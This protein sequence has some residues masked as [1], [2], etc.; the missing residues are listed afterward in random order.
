MENNIIT[1]YS[2][3]GKWG[4]K[5][6][7]NE[8]IVDAVYDSVTPFEGGFGVAVLNGEYCLLNTR[9]E[10]VLEPVY[11]E[12]APREDLGGYAFKK[13]GKWGFISLRG[14]KT[15]PRFEEIGKLAEGLIPVSESGKWGF[16]NSRFETVIP[17]SY[18]SAKGFRNG[19]ALVA[20]WHGN[21]F[22]IDRANRPV[23]DGSYKYISPADHRRYA[24]KHLN[25]LFTYHHSLPNGFKVFR[26]EHKEP[27]EAA[28][29]P[30]RERFVLDK[31]YHSVRHAG[32][33][34]IKAGI[35]TG[36]DGEFKWGVFDLNGDQILPV[37]FD[38]A[39]WIGGN[40]FAFKKG[41]KWG[42]VTRGLEVVREQAFDKLPEVKNGVL[43]SEKTSNLLI[44]R[45]NTDSELCNW[46][47]GRLID[48]GFK[49]GKT[50]DYHAFYDP[51]GS[52]NYY[53][54]E[55][56]DENRVNHKENAGLSDELRQEAVD[57][58]A[59]RSKKIE[60]TLLNDTTDSFELYSDTDGQPGFDFDFM[61]DSFSMSYEDAPAD[62][63]GLLNDPASWMLS[64]RIVR[65]EVEPERPDFENLEDDYAFFG[66]SLND[67]DDFEG[68]EWL[69]LDEDGNPIEEDEDED[70][71]EWWL[72]H[73]D[74]DEGSAESDEEP[75]EEEEEDDGNGNGSDSDEDE[76]I[77][78]D[79]NDSEES[80]DDQVKDDSDEDNE[81]AWSP[82]IDEETAE[83]KAA[84][85]LEFIMNMPD[86]KPA[87]NEDEEEFNPD[88]VKW[89]NVFPEDE[90]QK[91]PVLPERGAEEEERDGYES[92]EDEENDDDFDF[93]EWEPEEEEEP[94]V[95]EKP[96][97]AVR[98]L[99]G[100]NRS[101]DHW[102]K[103][104]I[105]DA[106]GTP[107]Y[108][109]K[110]SNV[111]HW[112][113]GS[114]IEF[115][116]EAFG[117]DA[118]LLNSRFEPLDPSIHPAEI[119]TY[120]G[121][122]HLRVVSNGYYGMVDRNGDL[123]IEPLFRALSNFHGATALGIT[124]EKTMLI[125]E[126]YEYTELPV[127]LERF[128]SFN[129]RTFAGETITADGL[130]WGLMN[131]KG[132]VLIPFEYELILPVGNGACLVRRNGLFG[133]VDGK[134]TEIL[135]LIW[136]GYITPSYGL[137]PLRDAT[138]VYRLYDIERRVMLE[139]FTAA[140]TSIQLNPTGISEPGEGFVVLHM[141]EGTEYL[142]LQAPAPG[143]Q[144]VKPGS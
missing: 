89:E 15:E 9:G 44:W 40:C 1:P 21:R 13:E 30:S 120:A 20:D 83:R 72:S 70:N 130:N 80:E 105:V 24:K 75:G 85:F 12:I 118:T 98:R 96:E 137:L 119:D 131:I 55:I 58:L 59:N 93:D 33:D 62:I 94:E 133:L 10:Q 106:D 67:G 35:K 116:E 51:S 52:I 57:Y 19:V 142:N 86:K 99:S 76:E 143:R 18:T 66:L 91:K 121:G 108:I 140:G 68:Y 4:F 54:Y 97:R 113:E 78:D 81:A 6:L 125:S 136:K 22:M 56:F 73:D 60:M 124:P 122:G 17:F 42:V 107:L 25:E 74:E 103:G 29:D 82:E 14:E 31:L 27:L 84:K 69:E 63:S 43:K 45:D 49:P 38:D 104:M 28:F 117:E 123:V 92:D 101:I 112:G 64:P 71:D 129:G 102:G 8:T 109:S 95:A 48:F 77:D 61:I 126:K 11:D 16:V 39:A 26:T 37:V 32:G 144:I 134:N 114:Y 47:A 46:I 88:F 5:G 132:E 34:F 36:R 7:N 23:S 53:S 41:S 2:E 139:T 127:K 110:K 115:E 128:H 3:S 111:Y 79:E 141:N 87:I 135:P 100:R 50:G 90:D 138:G 65:E